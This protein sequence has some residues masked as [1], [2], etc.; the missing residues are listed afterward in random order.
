MPTRMEKEIIEPGNPDPRVIFILTTLG[1]HIK[2]TNFKLIMIF[3]MQSM[4]GF[5]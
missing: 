3:H 1:G 5:G 2:L 4:R